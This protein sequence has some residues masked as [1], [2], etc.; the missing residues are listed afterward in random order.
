MNVIT[1]EKYKSIMDQHDELIELVIDKT[2][3]MAL[4]QRG[5]YPS[6]TVHETDFEERDGKLVVQFERYYCGDTDCDTY[7]LPYD[8]LYDEHYLENYKSVYEEEKRNAEAEKLLKKIEEEQEKIKQ[9]YDRDR[10]EYN[11]LKTKFGERDD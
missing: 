4:I 7:Y 6:G 9:Q 5:A 8:A 2:R 10:T 11:R 3:Q 1:P